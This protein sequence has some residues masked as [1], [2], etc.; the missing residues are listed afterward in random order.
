M[1]VDRLIRVELRSTG[2]GFRVQGLGYRVKD[3]GLRFSS[4]GFRV[5]GK[6]NQDGW[7][8]SN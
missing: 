7:V 6:P 8:S 5:Q 4:L 1:E 2:F 3:L